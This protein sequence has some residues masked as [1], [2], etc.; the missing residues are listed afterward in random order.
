MYLCSI[1][2]GGRTNETS[3][4]TFNMVCSHAADNVLSRNN[5]RAYPN[6][7]NV[8]VDIASVEVKNQRKKF[9]RV[10][11]ASARGLH[12]DTPVPLFG[13]AAVGFFWRLFLFACQHE[14]KIQRKYAQNLAVLCVNLC[15]NLATC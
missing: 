8:S 15:V 11:P 2:N 5:C 9:F 3:Y 10:A 1:I 6:S 13:I 7:G 14:S 12:P 4:N